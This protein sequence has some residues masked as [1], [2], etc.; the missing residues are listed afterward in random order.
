MVV[1]RPVAGTG[2][3][4]L[5][6]IDHHLHPDPAGLAAGF[7][8]VQQGSGDYDTPKDL[9]HY[10]P[11]GEIILIFDDSS[12]VEAKDPS[13]ALFIALSTTV[14]QLDHPTVPIRSRKAFLA[15]LERCLEVALASEEP[16]VF[17]SNM[18]SPARRLLKLFRHLCY[19]RTP[20]MT[21]N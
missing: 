19:G 10:L 20:P 13:E 5:A 6:C 8:H 21:L 11:P 9:D 12:K 3:A 1:Q 18:H 2:L 15:Q 17:P 16:P 4:D 14:Q 7:L